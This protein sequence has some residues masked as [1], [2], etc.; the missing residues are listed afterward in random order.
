MKKVM[1]LLA[2]A[3]L[4]SVPV[5]AGPEDAAMAPDGKPMAACDKQKSQCTK[6]CDKEKRLWFF[7]GEAYE[8]CAEKCESR[9]ASCMDTVVEDERLPKGM[10]DEEEDRRDAAEDRREDAEEMAE[11]RREDAE[12]M[13]GEGRDAA[14]SRAEDARKKGKEMRDGARQGAEGKD[15]GKKAGDDDEGV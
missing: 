10:R 7:K 4:F 5:Q 15:K 11:D 2:V 13:M 9:H 1:M 6:Q 3:G 8:T 14:E 12:E